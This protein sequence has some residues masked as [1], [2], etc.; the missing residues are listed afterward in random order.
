MN[1]RVQQLPV[2]CTVQAVLDVLLADNERANAFAVVS[3][4]QVVRDSQSS[5][6]FKKAEDRTAHNSPSSASSSS[7]SA[8]AAYAAAA[9]SP[10]ESTS[11]QPEESV[12]QEEAEEGVPVKPTLV[13]VHVYRGY[14]MRHHLLGLLAKSG[15]HST[16][17]EALSVQEGKAAPRIHWKELENNQRTIEKKG[18]HSVQQLSAVELA[19]DLDEEARGMWLCLSPYMHHHAPNVFCDT[20]VKEAFHMFRTLG[21]RHLFVLGHDFSVRGLITRKDL[22]AEAL[23]SSA[24][25]AAESFRD[26]YGPHDADAWLPLMAMR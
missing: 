6:I 20:T 15:M 11:D 22:T 16:E 13:D 5:S 18:Q 19:A 25:N 24:R 9:Q 8:A 3:R 26:T 21:L 2:V 10:D 4:V 12:P 17:A 1:P 14:L 7:S 23:E